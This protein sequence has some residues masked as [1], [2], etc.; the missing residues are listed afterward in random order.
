M[1]RIGTR[2]PAPPFS[3]QE[4]GSERSC[5]REALESVSPWWTLS[6][7]LGGLQDEGSWV[8]RRVTAPRGGSGLPRCA[9]FAHAVLTPPAEPHLNATLL[10]KNFR[11][12]AGQTDDVIPRAVAASGTSLSPWLS[13]WLCCIPSLLDPKLLGDTGSVCHACSSSP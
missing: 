9:A 8:G 12:F 2:P 13:F 4:T 6:P 11:I 7:S 5:G 1:A 3:R 10:T